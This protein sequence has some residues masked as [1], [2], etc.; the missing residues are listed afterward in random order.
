MTRTSCLAFA[1]LAACGGGDDPADGPITGDLA[2]SATWSGEVHVTGFINILPGVEII[3]EPGT[4]V[5]AAAATSI[6]VQGTLDVRGEP[7]A[8]VSIEPEVEGQHWLGIGV[9]GTYTMHYGRQIGGGIF[10]THPESVATIIDSE[11]SR[12]LGDYFV[13]NDGTLHVEHTNVGIPEEAE[14]THCNVHINHALSVTFTHNN[15]VGVPYGLMLYAGTQSQ[16][17]F[18]HNNWSGNGIDVEQDLGGAAVFDDSY[19][20]AGVPANVPGSSFA[21]PAAAP[22]ADCGPRP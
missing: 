22:L 10:L 6:D 13:V 20:A 15:N 5:R 8:V 21:N 19:F 4:I 3:V 16:N 18:T 7:G 12:A 2:E 17:D 14:S 11:V 9:S 1:L